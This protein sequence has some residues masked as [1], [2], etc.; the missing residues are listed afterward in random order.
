MTNDPKHRLRY[1]DVVAEGLDD[2]RFF[3]NR[4]HARFRTGSFVQGLALVTRIT[5]AAEE[6]NHHPDVTLTYPQV[7]VDLSSHDVDGVTSRDI[8]LARRITAIAA[9]L[10]IESAP[11]DVSTLELALDVPDAEE[12]KPFWAAVLGYDDHGE[13]PEIM[14]PG[15]RNNTLWFQTAP[16]A[17]GEV[18]QRFHLDIVVP[19]EVAEERVQAA[20]AAGGTLVSEDAVPA[21]WVLADAHGNKVCVC[22]ADG[23]QPAEEPAAD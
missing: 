21:F 15:G 3:L 4:L 9:E 10:G 13:W 14:D 6:A 11:R 22:T 2:W 20:V 1:P 12:V 18:Q 17:T 16:E 8:D 23:R 7:D 19:R 5:E